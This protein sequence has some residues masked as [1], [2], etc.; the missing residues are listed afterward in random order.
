MYSIKKIAEM[1]GVSRTAIHYWIK[2]DVT[3]PLK[4]YTKRERM[5]DV[6][7]ISVY[8]LNEYRK[9]RDKDGRC[10][11]CKVKSIIVDLYKKELS[12]KRQEQ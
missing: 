10:M 12:W 4:Y 5:R 9:R 3:E 7:Y 11:P 6:I 8:D 1:I 2:D